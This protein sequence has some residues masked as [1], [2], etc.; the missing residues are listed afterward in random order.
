LKVVEE[1]LLV[2]LTMGN[3]QDNELTVELYKEISAKLDVVIGGQASSAVRLQSVEDQVSELYRTVRGFNGTPGIVTEVALLREAVNSQ[4]ESPNL[5]K[6]ENHE[7]AGKTDEAKFVSFRWIIDTASN[8][9]FPIVVAFL[10]WFFASFVPT[11]WSHVSPVV[12]Q[13]TK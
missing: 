8:L 13:V 12:T 4:K 7:G 10:I 3:S 11:V 6:V 1:K 2:E 9:A 5:D